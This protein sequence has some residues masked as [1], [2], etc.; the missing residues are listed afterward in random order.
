MDEEIGYSAKNLWVSTKPYGP[1]CQDL[2][3]VIA[4][5]CEMCETQDPVSGCKDPRA[6][7]RISIV[8]AVTGE[9]LLDS[10]VKPNWPVVDYRTFVNGITEEHLEN[11][12]FTLRHAQAF[13]LALCS[14]ETVI[15]GH[16]LHNDL[17][18]M[19]LEHYCVADSSCLYEADDNAEASVSLR[20][21]A[22]A[23]LKKTMPEVH[24]SVNDAMTALACLNHCLDRKGIVDKIKRSIPDRP[25]YGSQLFLH[26]IPK[27]CEVDH[28]AEMFRAHT[29]IQ[30]M[31]VDVIT[32]TGESG[33]TL[34]HFRSRAHAQ[35][36]F[37]SL[38]SKVETDASG[39]LQKKVFLRTGG[40]IRVR[41]MAFEG[42]KRSSDD[43]ADTKGEDNKI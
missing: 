38:E 18:A 23:I 39:R 33:K 11:V 37:E 35:L 34:A 24:D 40:Y 12:K 36:A 42:S 14:Q 1:W 32:Y 9:L 16:A 22:A 19:R 21:L 29:S 6:L 13:L 31:Q 30:P 25:N 7:C 41:K 5:D 4:L 28:I 15:L 8:D 10:L 43:I 27:N 3:Q 17:A 26:R 20:D 2:P